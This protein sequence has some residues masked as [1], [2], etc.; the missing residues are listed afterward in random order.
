MMRKKWLREWLVFGVLFAMLTAML[1][2]SVWAAGEADAATDTAAGQQS[3]KQIVQPGGSNGSLEEDGV[4]I[5]KTITSTGSENVFDI[6]LQVKTTQDISEIYDTPD[7]AVVIVMDISNTM[8]EKFPKGSSSTRYNAAIA[9]AEDFITQFQQ[10]SA[11]SKAERKIGYVAFNTDAHRISQMTECKTAAQAAALKTTIKQGT[12]AIINSG[13]YADSHSRFTN[14]EAGLKMG[15]DMLGSVSAENKYMIFLSDG[16]PT[17]YI[18][19]GYNGYDPYCSSG[20]PGT[21]GVFYDKVSGKYCS[22]GTSYSDRAAVR[23]RLMAASVKQ[24][25]V[26][27]FSIGIDI[28]GQT[29]QRY[30]EHEGTNFSV[31]DRDSESYE[32][33]SAVSSD[34]FKN[35]LRN[36]I[37]SGYYYDSSNTEGLQSAYDAIFEEI[38]SE[39]EKKVI[40][41]WVAEDPMP[42]GADGYTRFISFFD[43]KG[44]LSGSR[45]AGKWRQ[46]AENTAAYADGK[47]SWDLKKSGYILEKESDKSVYTYSLKYRVRLA[48]EKDNFTKEK[49]YETNGTTTLKYVISVNGQTGDDR[50]MEFPVPEVK[51]YL[52]KL[53]FDKV[54]SVNR[55]PVNGAEFKL[56]HA[57]D[58]CTGG[59]STTCSLEAVTMQDTAAASDSNGRVKFDAIASGHIYRIYETKAAP[60][61]TPVAASG[62]EIGT[63]IVSYGQTKFI[64]KD[65]KEPVDKFIMENTAETGSLVLEKQVETDEEQ[66]LYNPGNQKTYDFTI[67]GPAR[68]FGEYEAVRSSD[69][70]QDGI[71]EKVIFDN[72]N[73]ARITLKDGERIKISGI[74]VT[75]AGEVYTITETNAAGTARLI[76]LTPEFKNGESS[77]VNTSVNAQV[78]KNSETKLICINRFTKPGEAECIP[79]IVIN[80]RVEGEEIPAGSAGSFK[81]T[82][83]AL[84]YSLPDG[85]LA[86]ETLTPETMP[87]LGE[88]TI[89]SSEIGDNKRITKDTYKYTQA[90]TYYYKI[91]ETA[92]GRGYSPATSGYY[93]KDT[94]TAGDKV[95]GYS[96]HYSRSIYRIDAL[97]S[98]NSGISNLDEVFGSGAELNTEGAEYGNDGVLQFI[99]I[100]TAPRSL[101]VQKTVGGNAYSTDYDFEFTVYFDSF[102]PGTVIKGTLVKRNGETATIEKTVTAAAEG[103]K[104]KPGGSIS[105]TLKAYEAMTFD[106]LPRDTKYSVTE[107]PAAGYSTEA[108]R[109]GQ[110]TEI[111]DNGVTG[112]ITAGSGETVVFK[113]SRSEYVYTGCSLNITKKVTGIDSSEKSRELMKNYYA[114]VNYGDKDIILTDF[115][116]NGSCWQSKTYTVTSYVNID[117]DVKEPVPPQ[118]EGYTFKETVIAGGDNGAGGGTAKSGETDSV[119][120]VN[121]YE[122]IKDTPSEDPE[123]PQKPDNPVI[124]NKPDNPTP[125]KPDKPV[126]DSKVVKTGDESGIAVK[127][128]IFGASALLLAGAAVFTARRKPRRKDM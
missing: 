52:G 50:T 98:A 83:K 71:A 91:T 76:M 33:G 57:D 38:R 56:K 78:E 81:F 60:G 128:G 90:G 37:G 58:L 92:A 123:D 20:Q 95:D 68:A 74:P 79:D 112:E 62:L 118:A 3:Q 77:T 66:G 54:D 11:G 15:A 55:L 17:T 101:T 36:S 18:S 13:G 7:A 85:G 75:A 117:Y 1:P 106:G 126:Y 111:K 127:A 100:F 40:G 120:V 29:I 73:T 105:F 103:D 8:N 2:A 110:K 25:G 115:T 121:D 53:D 46:G 97:Q 49:P 21:D 12:G 10:K 24:T 119:T 113:N 67:K 22:F 6:D 23:A 63:V 122:Q 109:N 114:V 51:G 64:P 87:T 59:D 116:W 88:F 32:L 72:D 93:I 35:W 84:G 14:I 86:E 19:G 69:D 44:K 31:V 61:Y 41:K 5:S 30:I 16:F 94:V 70:N 42:G 89:S 45:L 27:I 39:L 48:N 124:P 65:A 82:M 99:N 9:S 28:G 34:A 96:L 108:S 26:R 43:S 125:E 47:I 104:E 107:K 4:E 102:E 80:K